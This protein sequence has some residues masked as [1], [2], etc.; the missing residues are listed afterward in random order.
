M[1]TEQDLTEEIGVSS[2]LHRRAILTEIQKLQPRAAARKVGGELSPSTRCQLASAMN[3]DGNL[4]TFPDVDTPERESF[5]DAFKHAVAR[6]FN[7]AAGGDGGGSDP[8]APDDVEITSVTAGSVIVQF[9]VLVAA[10]GS[11]G[12]GA[13]ALV[14]ATKAAS[15]VS[16]LIV[17]GYQAKARPLLPFTDIGPPPAG[18]QNSPRGEAS[19]Y[20][21]PRAVST[22]NLH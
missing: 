3:F 10:I 17:G 8:I 12:A 16:G 2:R 18:S 19:G 5:D 21:T 1:M 22:S 15:S 9:T 14:Q 13:A 4:D 11:V 6:C 20:G 7:F